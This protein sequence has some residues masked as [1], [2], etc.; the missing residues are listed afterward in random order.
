MNDNVKDRW[1]LHPIIS[2]EMD[3]DDIF[4]QT[5]SA[6]FEQ[7][8]SNRQYDKYVS[9]FYNEGYREALSDLEDKASTETSESENNVLQTAFDKGYNSA[10]L[11]SKKLATLSA[12]VKTY[13]KAYKNISGSEVI[14][15]KQQ[16][17]NISVE[18]ETTELSIKDFLKG[19]EST[20]KKEQYDTKLSTEQQI[21]NIDEEWCSK[22]RDIV[23]LEDLQNRC[24]NLL[25]IEI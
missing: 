7:E 11:V 18:I 6:T 15:K 19:Y 4:D 8:F 12:S 5:D 13:L 22:F 21:A 9:K 20:P 24:A 25:D 16:L 17:E 3:V 14:Q 10:F 1:I 2:L 23:D